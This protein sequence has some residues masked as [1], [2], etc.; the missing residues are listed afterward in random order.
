MNTE[1]STKSLDGLEVCLAKKIDRTTLVAIPGCD[2]EPI[3]T[4]L[5]LPEKLVHCQAFQVFYAV[6]FKPEFIYKPFRMRYTL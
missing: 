1:Y 6:K 5:P 2:M 3:D 4:I